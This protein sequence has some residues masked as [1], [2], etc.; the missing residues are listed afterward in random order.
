VAHAAHIVKNQPVPAGGSGIGCTVVWV[1][2]ASKYYAHFIH[3]GVDNILH[4]VPVM[5]RIQ[6][7]IRPKMWISIT[8]GVNNFFSGESM[9]RAKNRSKALLSPFL[10]LCKKATKP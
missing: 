5:H 7:Y 9:G 10:S 6:S 1:W 8:T 4:P 2:K 3:R